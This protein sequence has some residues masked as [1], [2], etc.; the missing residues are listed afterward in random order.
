MFQQIIGAGAG[1]SG[2]VASFFAKKVVLTDGNEIVVDLLEKNKKHLNK[3]NL[4]VDLFLWNDS[5]FYEKY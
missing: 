1:L 4:F 5:K 3:N 2:F